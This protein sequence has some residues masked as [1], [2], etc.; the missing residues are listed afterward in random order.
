MSIHAVVRDLPD[1]GFAVFEDF[2]WRID[3]SQGDSGLREKLVNGISMPSVAF[4]RP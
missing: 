3:V 2:R 1:L 4:I